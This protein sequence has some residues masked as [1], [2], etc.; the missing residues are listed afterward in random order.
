MQCGWNL[1]YHNVVESCTPV[2]S[3]NH[4]KNNGATLYSISQTVEVMDLC[5]DSADEFEMVGCFF[6]FH[7]IIELPSKI[8]YPVIDLL[9]VEHLA[10]SASH[11]ASILIWAFLL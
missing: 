9:D 5:S 3:I 1:G 6:D 11:K 2:L 7:E 4:L 10:Q 8:Q